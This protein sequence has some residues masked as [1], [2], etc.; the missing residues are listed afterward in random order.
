MGY[1]S[2]AFRINL[3]QKSIETDSSYCFHGG[4]ALR[5]NFLI[6]GFKTLN[7]CPP[8][9]T[10]TPEMLQDIINTVRYSLQRGI[11]VV[12][13]NLFAMEFGVIYGFDDTEKVLFARDSK[14]DGPIPYEQLPNRRILCLC[15]IDQHFE[16]GREKMLKEAL[17]AILDHAHSR[18]GLSWDKVQCGIRGYDVWIDAFIS[19]DKISNKGNA[20]NLYIIANAR[21]H[22]ITFL[23]IISK[24]WDNETSS[25]KNIAQL[26]SKAASHFAQ[27]AE[28]LGKLERM[29]PYPLNKKGL[30][31]RV[32]ENISD[33]I[34]LL[35]TAK[36]SEEKGIAVLN[37]MYSMINS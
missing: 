5:R 31:P 13:W 12:G 26:A 7:I 36:A 20:L 14:F 17:T 25:G 21:R 24:Q 27:V 9:K 29:Y 2:H 22:A 18:D 4:E 35:E 1:T 15:V 8:V 10:I 30:N 23:E 33:S 11:P 19:G 16:N 37:E 6:L 32:K 3:R 28:S 34:E